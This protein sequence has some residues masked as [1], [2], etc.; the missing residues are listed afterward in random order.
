[1]P[2]TSE[3]QSNIFGIVAGLFNAAPGGQFL[4]EFSNTIDAGLTEAQLANILAAHPVFTDSIMSGATTTASQVAVLMNHYGLVADGVAGSA[5]SQAEAFFTNSIDSGVGFGAIAS[6]A[7]AF[8]LDNSVPAEFIEAAH[9]LKNKIIAA[10]IY[11]ASNS[12]TDL[13]TLQAPLTGL[14]IYIGTDGAD[15][16]TGTPNGDV[17]SGGMG[18]DKINLEGAQAARDILVLKTATDSQP[19]DANNDGRIT[20]L[21]NL[22]FDNVENFKVGA[23]NTD[24][25]VDITNFGFTGAQLGIVDAS[26]KV[27]TFDTD[28][29]SIPDLFSDSTAGDRGLAFSEIPLPPALGVSQSFLFIDANKDG[30]FTAADDMMVELQA[31]GTLPEV[32]FII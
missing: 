10:E 27:S 17:I 2:I 5:A 14:T 19:S 1:M 22:G 6:Q 8:L 11:S 26:S 31:T 30:D 7:T 20:I 9:L 15:T 3:Q 18:G 21:D 28:L 4:T 23:A 13:A 32:I 24:D 12:S 29:T 25:R 16:Y